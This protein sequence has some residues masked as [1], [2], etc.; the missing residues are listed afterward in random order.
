MYNFLTN[1]ITEMY[2]IFNNKLKYIEVT[3]VFNLCGSVFLL[4][5]ICQGK[6]LSLNLKWS[7]ICRAETRTCFRFHL[8]KMMP[9]GSRPMLSLVQLE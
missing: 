2:L 5:F 4:Y 7:T 8:Y 3:F 1:L 9:F 6:Q